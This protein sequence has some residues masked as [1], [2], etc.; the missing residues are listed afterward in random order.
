MKWFLAGGLLLVLG[1]GG[2]TPESSEG[3][4]SPAPAAPRPNVLLISLDTL[5]ADHLG[6]FG[7]RK[8]TSP[9]LDRFAA[10]GIRFTNCRSQ[11][12]WTLPSHMSLFTSLLP[13]DNGVDNVNKVLPREIVTLAQVLRKAGYRTAGLVNDGQM[14]AH[15]GFR[16]G[17]ETWREFPVDT[18]AGSCP[19]IT[20]QAINWLRDDAAGSPFFLFLHYYDCHDPY[21]APE[22]FRRKM[23]T[24]LTGA[25][26]HELC[27]RYHGPGQSLPRPDLLA[28]L[29]AAYD[30]EIAWLDDE[31]GRLLAAVP[32]D[33]LAVVFADHGEAF[34]EHGWLMHGATLYDEEIHVP[35]IVRLPAG[36][37]RGKVVEEPAMLLDVAPTILACCGIPVPAQFQGADLATLWQGG[38]LQQRLV[39][40]ETK[41]V[42]QGRYC[43]CAVQFPLKGIYSLF[44]GRFELY[45]LPDEHKDLSETDRAAAEALRHPLREWMESEQFWMIHAAGVGDYE[46][47]IEAPE[48]GFGLFIPVGLDLE[49][50][51]LETVAGGRVL[52]WHVYPGRDRPRSLFLQPARPGAALR[53]DF[54]V[55]G[56]ADP[57]LVY[58]GEAAAHPDA[59]PT[60]VAATL[61]PV[62]PFLTSAFTTEHAG[63]H[64]LRHRG[65]ARRP[66]PARVKALDEHTLQQLRTLGYLR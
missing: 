58:L 61:A 7:Y 36:Q 23:G 12:P 62:S 41:A 4:R 54:K 11:A 40:S 59:L 29:V 1:C 57:S 28:D 30:A 35:L 42:L 16:R 48:G 5:R 63:F 51:D 45:R 33:T 38:H 19:N 53:V 17:F 39:L 25:R 2:R 46:A 43:L 13:T 55:N 26:A 56:V 14:K 22:P 34:K 52:R 10:E 47:I 31:L 27:V 21:D 8:G 24:T 6:C 3:H 49:R 66:R 65:P 60:T 32:P 44:D 15:W 18:A 37:A 20:T 9:N 64:V 50:D